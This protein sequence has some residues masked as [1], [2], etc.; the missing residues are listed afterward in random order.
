MLTDILYNGK[1]RLA[2]QLYFCLNAFVRG[3]N[4]RYRCPRWGMFDYLTRLGVCDTVMS[5][6]DSLNASQNMPGNW[7]FQ[8]VGRDFS[9]VDAHSFIESHIIKSK[10]VK[11]AV[12]WA[13]SVDQSKACAIH[14]RCGDYL[15]RHIKSFSVFDR[16]EYLRLTCERMAG[17][18]VTQAYVFSDDTD[19]CRMEHGKFLSDIFENVF[20]PSVNDP[21]TD[22]CRLST[23][24]NKILWNSTF[25][26]WS[27]FIGNVLN[28]GSEGSVISPDRQFNGENPEWH[29]EDPKWDIVDTRRM[30]FKSDIVAETATGLKYPFDAVYIVT[31]RRHVKTSCGNVRRQLGLIGVGDIPVHTCISPTSSLIRSMYLGSMNLCKWCQEH[32]VPCAFGHY[33]AFKDALR[34]G[35]GKVLILEDDALF[36]NDIRHFR[37]KLSSIP[38]D[39]DIA[40]LDWV[41]GEARKFTNDDHGDVWLDAA[42]FPGGTYASSAAYIADRRALEV[43]ASNHESLVSRAGPKST[44]VPSDDALI[45]DNI[46]PHGL[47]SYLSHPPVV[48]QDWIRTGRYGGGS[49]A[50]YM[51]VK[52]DGFNIRAF[53]R[54]R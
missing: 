14:I 53:G 3:K 52:C 34:R 50:M 54:P 9:I 19:M 5:A 46:A 13:L 43:L 26:Y 10:A 11:E 23:F 7:Y 12:E 49:D 16:S 4:F 36:E 1:A 37:L 24:R 47:K 41:D 8:F 28:R 21:V 18:G 20:Y 44:L 31:C 35:Y 22:L 27:A 32:S 39:C 17:R 51:L 38:D 42:D 33:M 15:G 6:P 45:T 29:R 30:A 40:M 48:R 25:S 2:N